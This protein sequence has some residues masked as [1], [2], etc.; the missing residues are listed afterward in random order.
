MTEDQ[1]AREAEIHVFITYASEDSD[2]AAQVERF[3]GAAELANGLSV[4]RDENGIDAGDNFDETIKEN[5]EKSDITVVLVSVDYFLKPYVRKVE[6]PF[7]TQRHDDSDFVVVPIRVQAVTD[8]MLPLWMRDLQF[9]ARNAEV[10]SR[11]DGPNSPEVNDVLKKLVKEVSKAARKLRAV[12]DHQSQPPK[13]VQGKPTRVSRKDKGSGKGKLEVAALPSV[14]DVVRWFLNVLDQESWATDGS[15]SQRKR[16]LAEAV[17]TAVWRLSERGEVN[18]FFRKAE[19]IDAMGFRNPSASQ[20]N[21]ITSILIKLRDLSVIVPISEGGRRYRANPAAPV[22][23]ETEAREPQDSDTATGRPSLDLDAMRAFYD[24][25]VSLQKVAEVWDTS[26]ER[27]RTLFQ[28]NG[29]PVRTRAES[30]HREAKAK[31]DAAQIDVET[32]RRI[33]DS[34]KGGESLDEV[35]NSAKRSKDEVWLVL[36]AAEEAGE[37]R[38]SEV[39]RL[40]SRD[41]ADKY[42]DEELIEMLRQAAQASA[43]NLTAQGFT[44]YGRN[45]LL[46]DGRPWPTKQTPMN[47]FESWRNALRAAGLP[48]NP[49]AG[50]DRQFSDAACI[51]AVEEVGRKLG[52]AP[53]V[54]EYDGIAQASAGRLPSVATVRKRLGGWTKALEKAGW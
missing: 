28:Q 11:L 40:I 2:I 6:L 8:E 49:K 16:E 20:S 33:I 48:S 7:L 38:A 51:R 25:G 44:D 12:K 52:R 32:H 36:R 19:I 22:A 4:F 39:R 30:K 10:P 46:P 13:P 31:R 27:V 50:P 41:R 26:H 35:C 53:S 47:R 1:L 15:G 45:R 3:L 14:D 21:D 43:G 34:V 9:V 5:L 54:N 23:Q 18:A 37:L 24:S 29:I 17:I 42:S